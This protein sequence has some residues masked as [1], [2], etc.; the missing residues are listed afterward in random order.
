MSRRSWKGLAG[1]RIRTKLI[2]GFGTLAFVV[3]V[4]AA[5]GTFTTWSVRDSADQATKHDDRLH[6]IALELEV[7]IARA[8]K[9]VADFNANVRT[10]GVDGSAAAY[11]PVVKQELA[12]AR[13]LVD[14]GLGLANSEQAADFELIRSQLDRFSSEYSDMVN[15]RVDRGSGDS[16]REGTYRA[17]A[18]TIEDALAG[19]TGVERVLAAALVVRRSSEDF[20]Q[21]G[22]TASGQRA[23]AAMSALQ[24]E[25]DAS[26]A[27]NATEKTQVR[28]AATSMSDAFTALVAAEQ[29]AAGA[30]SAFSSASA[31][32][33]GAAS[34]VAESALAASTA[35]HHDIIATSNRA[36]LQLLLISVIAL[37]MASLMAIVLA[38]SITGPVARLVEASNRMS[39][40]ELDVD[41]PSEGGDEIGQLA[42]AL[43]RMQASLRA[44][45][46]RLRARRAAA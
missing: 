19:K 32:A 4:V 41:I 18:R 39:L 29:R 43:R 21:R 44:A 5:I 22:D 34:R 17:Q 28:A 7:H 33:T 15:A 12:S 3:A 14:E 38:R 8:Q 9:G 16:G 45:I 35:A 20:L 23:I 46:E 30:G 6:A 24:Q 27:L 11:T 25:A 42:E 2:T 13:A 36:T 26:A 31:S 1:A 37:L 10:L 40:G